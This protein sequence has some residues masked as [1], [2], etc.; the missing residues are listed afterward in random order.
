MKKPRQMYIGALDDSEVSLLRDVFVYAKENAYFDQ[1]S[2][3]GGGGD[4]RHFL[5]P[6]DSPRLTAKFSSKLYNYAM[7]DLW[8]SA[9]DKN[10]YDLC[11][12]IERLS[13]ESVR[14]ERSKFDLDMF[15]DE[16]AGGDITTYNV[17]RRHH[18]LFIGYR[19]DTDDPKVV[20]RF[21]VNVYFYKHLSRTLFWD[22]SNIDGSASGLKTAKGFAYEA[23]GNVYLSGFIN[24][25]FG[26]EFIAFRSAF[27]P[28]VRA[29]V[30]I[31][32][33]MGG[34]PIAK[35]CILFEATRTYFAS[36]LRTDPEIEVG[37]ARLSSEDE[38][39]LKKEM[40]PIFDVNTAPDLLHIHK[41]FDFDII[42]MLVRSP[43]PVGDVINIIVPKKKL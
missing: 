24:V 17:D 40:T 27:H 7:G 12:L 37:G 8:K 4:I 22:C 20:L 9:Y 10:D 19:M 21:A 34:L 26:C 41:K 13:K 35:R 38:L 1:N 14:S 2:F 29:G 30:I 32:T 43:G 23:S 15:T 36:L 3:I 25:D 18:H 11:A 5:K 42:D 39:F 28:A 16:L 31:T 33:T 6:G